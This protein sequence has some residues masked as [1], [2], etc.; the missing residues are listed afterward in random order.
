MRIARLMAPAL[1]FTTAVACGSVP[2]DPGAR[3]FAPAGVIRGTVLYQ[4]PRPCS[5]DGHIVGNAILLVFD[6]RNPPPPAGLANTAVNFADVTGDVLFANEPR[7][8][9]SDTY[10]PADH[11]FHETITVSAPFEISPLVGGSYMIEAF[12]DYT[13]DFLPTFKF[14][15]LPERGD[16]AGGYLDTADAQK[17]INVGNPNYTPKFLPVDIGIPQPLP[18]LGK[19]PPP[20]PIPNYTVPASGFVAD[21]VTV[22]IGLALPIARPYFYPQGGAVSLDS[23]QKLTVAYGSNDQ[24]SD[25][26]AK[27]PVPGALEDPNDPHHADFPPTQQEV[28][29]FESK[30][31][32]LK[33]VGGL[34]SADGF[35]NVN[36][37]A[38]AID[39]SNPFH[40]QL[41]KTGGTFFV[42][43]NAIN[44]TGDKYVFQDIPEGQI[45]YLW[46]LVVLNKLVDDPPAPPGCQ[47]GV[48]CSYHTLDPASL[49]AQGDL[50]NP[51]IIL[52]GITLLGDQCTKDNPC[53]NMS[54]PPQPE[55]IYWTALDANPL[56]QALG[57]TA[58]VDAQGQPVKF[59]QDHVSVLL[60]PSVICFDSLF[61][62]TNPDKRGTLV[63][64]AIVGTSADL[65]MGKPNTPIVPPSLLTSTDP[66]IA[67]V[68][69]LVKDVK[70][71]CLPTG[72]YAINLVYPDGQAWT[73]PNE[74]GACSGS[75]GETTYDDESGLQKGQKGQTLSCT[76]KPRPVLYSQGNRAVVEIVP[77][78]DP[79][80]CE[81]VPGPGHPGAVP[82]VCMPAAAQ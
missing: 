32:H 72:R 27:N 57:A 14:R 7:Y 50:N 78:K 28:N 49:T 82:S 31:P 46:P 2:D 76:I 11:G 17:A 23:N 22:S 56:G 25:A 66:T 20:S 68:A 34:P 60:R 1:L 12:F 47:P 26:P 6:R 79:G 40:F 45:P 4:G 21:N 63:T 16:I 36:E 75:E 67:S 48:D 10:C 51:V 19:N 53:A 62:A 35:N 69:N 77:A 18:D 41:P 74:A 55:S 15:N 71:G 42:W 70:V 30:F 24:S 59:A 9:G 33:L 5:R 61:D 29:L 58:L 13:G 43:Q 64:P 44:P 65:P 73:V 81:G 39:P 52:Q 37:Q 80:V 3:L 8:T 54:A 38:I